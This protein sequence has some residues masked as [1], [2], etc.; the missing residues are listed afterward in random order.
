MKAVASETDDSSS[1][2]SSSSADKMKAV[3]SETDY[4]VAPS[5]APLPR[6]ITPGGTMASNGGVRR[7]KAVYSGVRW[8]MVVYV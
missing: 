1:S 5:K 2:S 4:A 6:R 3:A 8:C 7:C